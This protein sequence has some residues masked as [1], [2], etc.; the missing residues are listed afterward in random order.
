MAGVSPVAVPRVEQDCE[1]IY[2]RASKPGGRDGP[3]GRELVG[4]P[5]RLTGQVDPARVARRVHE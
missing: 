4:E 5:D 1:V 2:A 3:D